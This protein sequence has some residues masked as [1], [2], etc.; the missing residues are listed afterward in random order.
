M[1]GM[2]KN[3]IGITG[4]AACRSQIASSAKPITAPP[5]SAAIG[6]ELHAKRWPPD[7]R[8]NSSASAESVNRSAPSRSGRKRPFAAVG[9]CGMRIASSAA[10]KPERQVDGEHRSPAPVLGEVGPE[11]RPRRAR[12]REHGREI[13]R[14]A[15]A[16]ARR[17]VLADQRL[18]ECHQ[19]ASAKALNGAS[20][21]QQEQRRR[22]RASQRRDGKNG[23]ARRAACAV[24][25]SDH[26]DAHTA[27]PRWSPPAGTR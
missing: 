12:E 11:H 15:A 16:L 5:M 8:A 1:A 26:R 9:G 24:D 14:E 25:R 23:R 6:H 20:R 7:D 27:A 3:R 2:P 19:A 10:S 13:A 22:E 4:S 18:R 17:H 21:D